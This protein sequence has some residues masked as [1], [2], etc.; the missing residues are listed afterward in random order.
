MKDEEVERL[1]PLVPIVNEAY[2]NQKTTARVAKQRIYQAIVK[3]QDE[4]YHNAIIRVHSQIWEPHKAR[5]T[6]GR[7]G[8]EHYKNFIQIVIKNGELQSVEALEEEKY[9]NSGEGYGTDVS[10]DGGPWVEI[11]GPTPYNEGSMYT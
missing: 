10:I 2:N 11:I 7:K 8:F 5:S 3:A 4:G 6:K 9:T 1:I